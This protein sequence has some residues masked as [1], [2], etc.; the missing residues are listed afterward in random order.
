M[1][2]P[3]GRYIRSMAGHQTFFPNPLPPELIISSALQ[4]KIEQTTHA[5]GKVEMCRKLLPN[6]DLLIYSS[7]QR[8]AIASS[9]IEG[10]IASVDELIRF[11]IIE[12]SERQA[13]REVANYAE[14]LRW[15]V[16]E[17]ERIPISI[18]LILGL[19]ER[20]LHGVRGSGQAGTFKQAQ[21]Y[22]GNTDQITI[23]KATFVPPPPELVLFLMS[24]LEQYINSEQ[25]SA[26]LIQSALTHYQFETIHPFHDGNGRV[27]RLLII[28]QLIQQGLLT[29]P[30][31]YP[32][33]YFES[34][35][36]TYYR[37]LQ[38]VREEGNWLEWIEFFIDGIYTQAQSTIQL[39][40]I[41]IDLPK[42][43]LKDISPRKRSV[44]QEVLE[45]F[46]HHPIRTIRDITDYTGRYHTSIQPVI[47]EL[48]SLEIIEEISGK[49]KGRTYACRPIIDI[50]IRG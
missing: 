31:I 26:R 11:Q 17:L 35:R 14:A 27:G 15:G 38:S 5:L 33:V 40:D 3:S 48:Q 29:A 39:T 8:E 37:L 20:L 42:L 47:D 43:I 12:D 44:A 4:N 21:N 49:Q 6:A 9:T 16:T 50:I 10:T 24:G 2:T 30:L 23:D 18:N 34:R 22:I 45:V 46:F 13:V 1:E 7:L 28:L 32:S 19:H 25:S 36:D 41:I